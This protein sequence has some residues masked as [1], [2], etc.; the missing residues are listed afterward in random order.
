MVGITLLQTVGI[1]AVTI[2]VLSSPQIHIS[3]TEFAVLFSLA[4][5]S[6]A[7]SMITLYSVRP[8]TKFSSQL[9]QSE[10]SIEDLNKLN[11]TLR[12]Q[13]HDFLNHLQ[14]VYSLVDLKAFDEASKYIEKVYADIQKVSNVLKTRIPAVNAILQAKIQMCESRGIHA[15]VDISS[16]LSD[17]AIPEWEL[18]RVLGNI[19]DN[20][21]HALQESEK[22]GEKILKIEIFESIRHHGFRITNNGPAIPHNI[23]KQIFD[24][25][26]TTRAGRGDGM[27][28]TI[29]RNI[30]SEY[31]GSLKVESDSEATSFEGLVPRR[32]DK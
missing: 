1:A 19:I 21:I 11:L 28:L 32:S 24:P 20:S 30:L 22:E 5:I 3:Q 13:R 14:V 17:I 23:R 16:S 10:A 18:C 4:L 9:K 7:G 8:I 27:G 15:S 25:G 26:F 2:F 29:C 6:V 31:G 12:A